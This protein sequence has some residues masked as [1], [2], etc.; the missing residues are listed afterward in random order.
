MKSKTQIKFG[1]EG[2]RALIAEAFTHD[3]VRIATQAIAEHYLKTFPNKKLKAAVGYD[4]RFLGI[5]FAKTVCEVLAGNGIQCVLTD[6]SIP[7]PVIS[8]TVVDLKLPF[9]LMVTASHNPHPYNGLKI[10]EAYGGS[11]FPATVKSVE[12]F[13][14]KTEV[15]SMSFDE[16][17]AKKLITFED[18]VTPYVAGIKSYINMPKVR[19]LKA[20]VL[21]DSMH[22]AGGTL[23]E[24][25]LK[26]SQC[27]VET[28]RGN[29]DPYFGG[30]APEPISKYL[31]GL[32][33]AV[34]HQSADIGIAN[35]GDADRLGII[36]PKG[37]WLN[38]GQVMCVMIKH[39]VQTRK[40]TGMIVKTLSNT[41][42]INR[43][44][45][46]LG[47]KL[48]EVPVGFKGIAELMINED[49]M[50]GGEESG[51]IG[52]N[53][54]LPERDGLVN[55]LLVLEAM[56]M[57]GQSLGELM[58]D[59]EKQYG[60]WYYGRHDLHLKADQ[61]E[62]LFD[63]LANN[64]P[65]KMAGM[66]IVRTSDMDGFKWVA[67]DDSWLLFRRSGTEPIVRLYC[68][69]PKKSQL[70]ELLNFGL[71]LIHSA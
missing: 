47:L 56:A 63:Q 7:T 34:K 31:Q 20:K 15:K 14:G 12:S 32:Q 10:K 28:L 25:M 42:M 48:V 65:N 68:E 21:V 9:G 33:K 18:M 37:R 54:Y 45:D 43:L 29:P 58:S 4:T 51:G 38:P 24:Q 11:A 2:W 26:G 8:R 19:K 71:K 40:A 52:L 39:L 35:D 17:E 41:M 49:V 55:G 53:G 64:P 22:G 6:K 13:L 30:T 57:S 69:T 70:E 44:C 67:A 46:D 59:L 62:R 66:D 3:N 16:A 1:T 23:I 60:R 50:V 27:S 61:V 36:D 5:A